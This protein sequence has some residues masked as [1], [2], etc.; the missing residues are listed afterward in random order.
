M[1]SDTQYDHF[2]RRRLPHIQPPDA[3]YFVTYRLADSIPKI[4][5]EK[6]R[7][8]WNDFQQKLVRMDDENKRNE[9]LA[10]ER[11]RYFKRYDESLDRILSGPVW[12]REGRVA[13]VVADAIQYRHSKEYELISYCIMPNHVH[14]VIYVGRNEVSPRRITD[15]P[16]TLTRILQSLKRYTAMECNKILNRS[17][18]FWQHESY[19]HIVRGDKQLKRIIKY[20]L[21]NPVSAGFVDRPDQWKWSYCRE[22]I[23]VD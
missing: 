8:D 10:V 13:K 11:R 23:R 5:L 3:T 12:L 7:S 19:D 2:Y 21:N 4:V 6:L 16:Y 1:N 15:S 9:L 20:V 18:Q 14:M 22:D 17:G